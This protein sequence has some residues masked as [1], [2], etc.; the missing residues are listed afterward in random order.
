[1]TVKQDIINNFNKLA[2]NFAKFLTK[3]CPNSVVANNMGN[4]SSI[5]S[6]EPESIITTF[7]TYVLKDK[8][9]IDAGDV[10]Y[11]MG[12]DYNEVPNLASHVVLQFKNVWKQL[13]KKDQEV[14]IKAM[15]GLCDYSQQYFM[16][17]YNI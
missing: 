9:K 3:K 12:K 6:S 14:V 15:Q 17:V 4:F 11:F 16:L 8:P 13:E 5:I 2:I 1:M 7:I 10:S